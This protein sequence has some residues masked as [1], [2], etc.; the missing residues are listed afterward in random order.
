MKFLLI[1]AFL[2][3]NFGC[4]T[5]RFSFSVDTTHIPVIEVDGNVRSL[6][7]RLCI[8]SGSTQPK[9]L[10]ILNHGSP[11]ST[12][13][14]IT[15]EGYDCMSDP[16]L[17]FLKRGFAVASPIRRGYGATGGVWSEHV[18]DCDNADF[19]H[20]GLETA[21]DIQAVVDNL[22]SRPD[23]QPDHVVI[24][25][26]SAGGWGS[27]AFNSLPHPKVSAIINM[28]GGRGGHKDNIPNKNCSPE[29]LVQAAGEFGKTSSTPMPW[30]YAANDSYFSPEVANNLYDAFTAAGGKA[31][32]I[33]EPAFGKDGHSLFG[34][35]DGSK[36]WGPEVE[37][38]LK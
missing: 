19:V 27:I 31:Q 33:L 20:A 5:K 24:V 2:I 30:I 18:G 25:G 21:R 4:A 6:K 23:I 8:P 37:K 28:A 29:K 15:L 22:T 34:A 35:K 26:H 17:W 12:Q 38:Y 32:L 36:I 16:A 9:R 11:P 7:T 13:A 10:V 14:R 1:A 3:F